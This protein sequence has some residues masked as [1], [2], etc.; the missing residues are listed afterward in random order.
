MAGITKSEDIKVTPREI[1]FVTQFE[2]NWNALKEAL[3]TIRLIKKEAG[4]TLKYKYAEVS[5]EDGEVEEGEAIPFSKATV[6]E[7]PFGELK[8]EKYAKATSMEAILEHGYDVAVGM[9]DEELKNQLQGRISGRLYDFMNEGTLT[10]EEDTFQMAIAMSQGMVRHKFQH[11]NKDV[12]DIAGFVNTLDAYRYL[13]AADI[14]QQTAFGMSYIKDFMGYKTLFLT[15]KVEAGT[16]I[17]TPVNNIVGYYVDPA[18][19]DLAKAGL[20]YATTGETN[21]IGFHTN[22]DYNH[23]QSDCFAIMGLDLFAEYI[24]GIAVLTF[25]KSEEIT[26][27]TNP[28]G[29]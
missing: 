18:T 8:L 23:A 27:P 25:G 24:D 20:T 22:G 2:A 12:T 15:D 19:S 3:G 13:G 1:D 28:E 5:L 4:A 6:K 26:T 7:K 16:V 29:E 11:M 9:T 10:G 14:V 21:L 17:S